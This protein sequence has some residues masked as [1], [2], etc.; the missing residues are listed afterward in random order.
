MSSFWWNF[1]HWLHWKFPFWQLLPVKPGMKFSSK[2]QH[3]RFSERLGVHMRMPCCVYVRFICNLFINKGGSKMNVCTIS[4]KGHLIS[5]LYITQHD[6]LTETDFDKIFVTGCTSCHFHSLWCSEWWK[7]RQNHNMIWR[8]GICNHRVGL[9]QP[10]RVPT[11][12]HL[13]ILSNA[14]SS[15]DDS[16]APPIQTETRMLRIWKWNTIDIVLFGAVKSIRFSTVRFRYAM[17]HLLPNTVE[18]RYNAV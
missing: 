16:T 5:I 8:L 12:R 1:H 9:R 18:C 13:A 10:D 17:Q 15:S 2:W 14:T 11:W 3:F 7:F 4:I 6:W